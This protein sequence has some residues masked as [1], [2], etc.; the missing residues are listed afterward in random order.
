[1]NGGRDK[2]PPHI[3]IDSS[4]KLPLVKNR[5]SNAG[6]VDEPEIE[7]GKLQLEIEAE[8]M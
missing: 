7:S 5:K 3:N 4:Q 8:H 6:K 1:L 2:N